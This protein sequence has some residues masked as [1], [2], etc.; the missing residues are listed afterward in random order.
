[1]GGGYGGGAPPGYGGGMGGG[2]GS[3]MGRGMGG[4]GGGYGRRRR[5]SGYGYDYYGYNGISDVD[6]SS[7]MGIGMNNAKSRAFQQ[8]LNGMDDFSDV[9]DEE[10]YEETYD[11]RQAET[12]TMNREIIDS[13]REELGSLRLNFGDDSLWDD[14]VYG[15]DSNHAPF[16][17]KCAIFQSAHFCA[18]TD[19]QHKDLK[20]NLKIGKH[21]FH[22]A[23][24]TDAREAMEDE[25]ADLEQKDDWIISSDITDVDDAEWNDDAIWKA[26][27]STFDSK[28]FENQKLIRKCHGTALCLCQYLDAHFDG[29]QKHQCLSSK[30]KR[31]KM[32]D[33]MDHFLSS[34]AA[35]REFEDIDKLKDSKDA[36]DPKN[37]KVHDESVNGPIHLKV[38]DHPSIVHLHIMSHF[39][40]FHRRH[41][42]HRY[43]IPWFKYRRYQHLRP[44]Q[45]P[46]W[47]PRWIWREV[48]GH[49]TRPRGFKHNGHRDGK[50][51]DDAME[52]E[53]GDYYQYDE[54]VMDRIE[55]AMAD[56]DD[57]EDE[58]PFMVPLIQ[59]TSNLLPNV[60]RNAKQV[61]PKVLKEEVDNGGIERKLKRRGGPERYGTLPRQLRRRRGGRRKMMDRY[62]YYVNEDSVEDRYYGDYEEDEGDGSIWVLLE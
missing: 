25:F 60:L 43:R 50:K 32:L 33:V 55:D 23:E 26:A 29:N 30:M 47:C 20:L 40:H 51:E 39:P 58:L 34:P 44:N 31:H 16:T 41:H 21:K 52:S 18:T 7:M 48:T 13:L 62:G 59:A 8:T 38:L 35:Q 54:N 42:L 15:H 1:M 22:K 12:D 2:Y 49:M 24:A 28:Q 61:L 9:D 56:D 53:F 46:P 10:F 5:L 37:V 6:M 19:P 17:R 4:M 45:R 3:G 11:E 27:E 14:I 57:F 36:K